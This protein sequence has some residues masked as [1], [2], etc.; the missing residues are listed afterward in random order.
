[1]RIG[2]DL[3]GLLDDQPAFFA[4]LTAAL[5]SAATLSPS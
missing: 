5:R 3:D 1:V 4:F 2:V